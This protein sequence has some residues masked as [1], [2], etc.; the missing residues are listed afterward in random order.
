M[1]TF[2]GIQNSYEKSDF[3]IVPAGYENNVSWLKGTKNGPKAIIDASEELEFY[4][5]YLKDRICDK[6]KVCTSD[7]LKLKNKNYEKMLEIVEKTT[8]KALEGKKKFGLIGGEHSI[9][10]GAVNAISKKYKNFSILHLDAHADLRNSYLGSKYN[11]ACVMRR[12]LEKTKNIVSVGVRSYSKDEADLIKRK[13]LNVFGPDFEISKVINKLK[14]NVYITL[15]LDVFDPSEV[16]GVGTPQP[17]G[18]RWNQILDLIEKIAKN[19]EIVSFDIVELSPIKNQKISEFLAAK[20]LYN[21]IG[22]SFANR[23]K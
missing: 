5:T 11:H 9:I 12:A 10:L 2:L 7:P 23:F 18:L 20:L 4:S 17:G 14:R 13:K 16:P 22:Y 6:V 21:L 8:L 15:D 1:K 3:I 19:K